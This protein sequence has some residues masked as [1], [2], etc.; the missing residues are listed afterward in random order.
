MEI[1]SLEQVAEIRRRATEA[2]LE[3]LQACVAFLRKSYAAKPA[4]KKKDLPSERKVK[5]DALLKDIMEIG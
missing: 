1:T 5:Q 3:E 4:T 2:S